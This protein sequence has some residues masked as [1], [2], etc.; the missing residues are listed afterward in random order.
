[1]ASLIGM[2]GSAEFHPAMLLFVVPCAALVA[3]SFFVGIRIRGSELIIVSWFRTYRIHRD[4]IGDALLT[5]YSG[6]FTNFSASRRIK[7]LDLEVDGRDRE[8]SC[9]AMTRRGAARATAE[10]ARALD[11]QTRD[12]DEIVVPMPELGRW[13]RG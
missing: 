12:L 11:L 1:M 5:Q 4:R 6:W 13:G 7:I 9:T 2:G 3:R 10:L 8:F